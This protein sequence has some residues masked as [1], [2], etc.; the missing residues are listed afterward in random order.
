MKKGTS[1]LY[2]PGAIEGGRIQHDCGTD[3]SISYFLEPMIA[4]APFSKKPFVLVLEGITTDHV[5]PSV[6]IIRTVLLPQL[7]RFGVDQNLELKVRYLFIIQVVVEKGEIL[8]MDV[9]CII[10]FKERCTTIGRWRGYIFLYACSSI[11]TCS[12]YRRRTY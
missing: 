5:D 6:D 12:I 8:I 4:L 10:D 11:K 1:F 9:L 2:R 7:K 3:R